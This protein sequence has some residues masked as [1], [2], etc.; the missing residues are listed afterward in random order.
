MK[1]TEIAYRFITHLSKT[2]YSYRLNNHKS[3]A[4]TIFQASNELRST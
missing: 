3:G 2:I 4:I 1:P